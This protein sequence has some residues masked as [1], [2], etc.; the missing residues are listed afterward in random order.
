MAFGGWN[1]GPRNPSPADIQSTL[2]FIMQSKGQIIRVLDIM[3]NQ[4]INITAPENIDAYYMK[5]NEATHQLRKQGLISWTFLPGK[6][7]IYH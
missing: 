7:R 1:Q 5:F 4:G 2:N 3:A 6:G